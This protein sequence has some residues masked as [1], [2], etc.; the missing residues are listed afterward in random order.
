MKKNRNLYFSERS[1]KPKRHM[2]PKALRGLLIILGVAAACL[3]AAVL[4]GL[5]LGRTAEKIP[6]PD[7]S[8]T[9][10][11]PF[12]PRD[13]P[14]VNAGTM[15]AGEVL[16]L[17]FEEGQTVSVTVRDEQGTVFIRS[18]LLSSLGLSAKEGAPDASELVSAI[19]GK[20]AR[21]SLCL[22][23]FAPSAHDDVL[24]ERLYGI[25]ETLLTEICDA[26]PD[27]ILLFG[28]PMDA[29]GI[30][31]IR[32]ILIRLHERFTRTAFCVCVPYR[33]LTETEGAPYTEYLGCT[34]FLGLDLHGAGGPRGT[35]TEQE[36]GSFVLVPNPDNRVNIYENYFTII[37]SHHMRLLP[38]AENGTLPEDLGEAG[39]SDWQLTDVH[40]T[41]G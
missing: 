27:E 6:E 3:T 29:D 40:K 11:I 5:L 15:S 39:C 8:E 34:D 12:E 23:L 18:A 22:Y 31:R 19:H 17:N 7:E 32:T 4:T 9:V 38:D 30:A 16:S 41:Q 10:R 28:C 14:S 13:V 36:D 37:V 1:D 21:A 35:L 20:G 26:E 2:S 25:E 24:R 33:I